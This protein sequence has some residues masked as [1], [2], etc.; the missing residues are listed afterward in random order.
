MHTLLQGVLEEKHS[1]SSTRSAPQPT[2]PEGTTWA[3]LRTLRREG[4]AGSVRCQGLALMSCSVAADSTTRLY[5]SSALAS[6]S[7]N[8]FTYSRWLLQCHRYIY[9]CHFFLCTYNTTKFRSSETF[10]LN[11]HF[12]CDYLLEAEQIKV[13]VN[14][15]SS[16]SGNPQVLIGHFP[17]MTLEWF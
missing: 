5:T 11:M 16:F 10:I 12:S 17:T 3:S 6:T 8:I 1:Q 13:L 14:V 4:S 2:V 15:L 9:F 7:I